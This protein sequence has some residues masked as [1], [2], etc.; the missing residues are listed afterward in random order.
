MPAPRSRDREQILGYRLIERL[1]AGGFGEVWK[2]EA[3]GGLLKAVK[4][5]YGQM[6]GRQANQEV[7]ALERIK[8][9]RHPFVLSLERVE[10][11]DGQLIMVSELAD[12]T[13]LD[14]FEECR[15]AGGHGIPRGELLRYLR[16]RR[17]SAR[18]PYRS[19]PSPAPGHQAEQPVPA[20]RPSEGRRFRAGAGDQ[21]ARG[22]QHRGPESRLRRARVVYRRVQLVFGSVCAGHCLSGDAH[23]NATVPR[24][25]GAAAFRAAY[26]RPAQSHGS[27]RWRA[28]GPGPGSLKKPQR[29]VPDVR[30]DDPGSSWRRGFRTAHPSIGQ[31]PRCRA[32]SQAQERAPARA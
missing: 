29:P 17:R 18:S 16:G 8:E 21:S 15:A 11:V 5:V 25:H 28:R 12:K 27:G 2:A 13:L 7:K 20:W 4:F 24:T 30:G 1:G 23:R 3:P 22:G 31:K 26:T 10:I 6:D 19:V 32:G 14:R 9:V